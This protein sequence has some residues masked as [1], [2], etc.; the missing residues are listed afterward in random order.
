ML[1]E[2]AFAIFMTIIFNL[3]NDS[4]YDILTE[5]EELYYFIINTFN[6]D[7]TSNGAINL[8]YLINF[9]VGPYTIYLDIMQVLSTHI[10]LHLLLK[11]VFHVTHSHVF[12][13]L[14]FK[15]KKWVSVVYL[16]HTVLT[17]GSLFLLR[18]DISQ[19]FICIIAINFCIQLTVGIIFVLKAGIFWVLY[20]RAKTHREWSVLVFVLVIGLTVIS[21]IFGAFSNLF[22]WDNKIKL[23]S[24]QKEL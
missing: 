6:I 24:D 1:I 9:G 4:R 2:L 7:S 20:L 16:I 13:G 21:A 10:L 15:I 8:R 12:T 22:D 5:F 11:H 19:V 14:Y 3:V 23:S 18:L 17:I